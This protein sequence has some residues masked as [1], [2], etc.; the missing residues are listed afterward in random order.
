MNENSASGWAGLSGSSPYSADNASLSQASGLQN[1]MTANGSGNSLLTDPSISSQEAQLSQPTQ[2]APSTFTQ[3]SS[4]N[5]YP[6]FSSSQA[7]LSS[8]AGYVSPNSIDATPSVIAQ[9]ARLGMNSPA[10]VNMQQVQAP[11]G[12]P[13][14]IKDSSVSGPLDY[15]LG[16]NNP[17]PKIATL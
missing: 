9:Q 12:N 14:A 2:S 8:P 10:P 13:W 17:P 1:M 11:M 16:Q 3:P 7:G 5:G 15:P 6:M 4:I